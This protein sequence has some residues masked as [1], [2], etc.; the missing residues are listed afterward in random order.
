M[1]DIDWMG[2]MGGALAV[3]AFAGASFAFAGLHKFIIG[4]M[5]LEVAKLR[6]DN[7]AL[8]ERVLEE[9]KNHD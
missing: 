3:A 9:V 5:K 4:P 7:M 1:P 8:F 2:P 6:K